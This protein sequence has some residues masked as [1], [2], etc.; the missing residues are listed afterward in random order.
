MG[1]SDLG[2]SW[3]LEVRHGKEITTR[4]RERLPG[5]LR[6]VDNRNPLPLEVQLTEETAVS[7]AATE[8]TER[9]GGIDVIVNNVGYGYLGAVEEITSADVRGKWRDRRR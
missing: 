1:L 4:S 5:S 2:R 9:F 6:D 8:R 7:R 3:R